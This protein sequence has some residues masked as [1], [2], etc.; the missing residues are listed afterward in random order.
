MIRKLVLCAFVL[1]GYGTD[2]FADIKF[3]NGTQ[4]LVGIRMQNSAT[5]V[6]EHALLR[7]GEIYTL[8]ESPAGAVISTQVITGS[9]VV[10]CCE[11]LAIKDNATVTISSSGRNADNCRCEIK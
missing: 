11:W 10:N 5:R 4:S 3:E 7:P 2:A 9:F 6:D 1:A 8:K